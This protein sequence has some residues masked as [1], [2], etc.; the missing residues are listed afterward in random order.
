M[1]PFVCRDRRYLGCKKLDEPITNPA[2]QFADKEDDFTWLGRG[3]VKGMDTV[4]ISKS[5]FNKL[6][7][8]IGFTMQIR[9]ASPE[10]FTTF[11]PLHLQFH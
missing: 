4:C 1:E 7:K 9:H 10:F 11:Q 5:D 8:A 2:I 3:K 6:A